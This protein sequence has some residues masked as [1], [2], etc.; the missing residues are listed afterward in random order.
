MLVVTKPCAGTSYLIGRCCRLRVCM[1]FS[2]EH[3][4]AAPHQHHQH[5]QSQLLEL[6]EPFFAKIYMETR[7]FALR[8]ALVLIPSTLLILVF[9]PPVSGATLIPPLRIITSENHACYRCHGDHS[10][11]EARALTV[12]DANVAWRGCGC[13][14]FLSRP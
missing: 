10:T 7:D 4:Y 6:Y 5:E 13:L 3:V 2:Y 9:L 11:V 8:K 12:S 14:R 1:P